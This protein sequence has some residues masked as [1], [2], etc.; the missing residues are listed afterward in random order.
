MKK[1]FKIIVIILFITMLSSFIYSQNENENEN[2][3]KDTE[4]SQ[5]GEQ[6]NNEDNNNNGT[7]IGLDYKEKHNFLR[8]EMFLEDLIDFPYKHVFV[9]D[10]D[11]DTP[12]NLWEIKEDPFTPDSEKY[13]NKPIRFYYAD[14]SFYLDYGIDEI[15]DEES[16]DLEKYYIAY[17]SSVNGKLIKLE[18]YKITLQELYIFNSIEKPR[19]I[20]NYNQYQ[21]KEFIYSD[22]GIL[23]RI[24]VYNDGILSEYITYNNYN[25]R[26]VH[27]ERTY[28]YDGTPNGRWIEYNI[29]GN[30]TMELFWDNGIEKRKVNYIYNDNGLEIERRFYIHDQ[31]SS[32]MV[33]LKYWIRKEDKIYY[34]NY[35][36]NLISWADFIKL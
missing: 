36:D 35:N 23:I 8:D 10:I 27:L 7:G 33:L 18:F 22:N 3:D 1:I 25:N 11:E 2:D 19:Y 13:Y 14:W 31:N 32:D 24:N 29:D 4:N 20:I 6:D 9:E 30:K 34:Y 17:Y 21:L 12:D 16:R 28:G 26:I 15:S 5:T